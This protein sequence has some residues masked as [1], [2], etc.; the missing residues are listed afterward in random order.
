MSNKYMLLI[1][2]LI[3]A[4]FIIAGVYL[5]LNPSS[6]DGGNEGASGG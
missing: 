6:H 2:I 3:A 1:G 4:V 5:I